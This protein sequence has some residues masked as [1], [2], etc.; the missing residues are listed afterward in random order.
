MQVLAWN[1]G[2]RTGNTIALGAEK[3]RG[4]NNEKIIF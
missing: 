2:S 1:A 3:K 4:L